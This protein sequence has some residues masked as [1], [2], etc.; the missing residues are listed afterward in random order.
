L[1]NKNSIGDALMKKIILF[2]ICLIAVVVMPVS[3]VNVPFNASTPGERNLG[4]SFEWTVNNVS[5]LADIHYNF[6]AYAFRDLGS[7]YTYH[8][9][10]WGQNFNQSA[11]PG[12]KFIAV[13]IRGIGEGTTWIGWGADRFNLWLYGNTTIKPEA[14]HLE[15]LP[16]R[17]GSENYRPA[18]IL[19]LENR[20]N[21]DGSWLSDEWYGWKD[22]HE[23]DRLEPGKS[24]AFDGF[25]IYQVPLQTN[26]ED[27]RLAGWFGFYG[28]AI[29]YLS[30][31]DI[32][33]ESP[34]KNRIIDI[35]LIEIQKQMGLRISDRISRDKV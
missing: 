1:D 27:L 16:I 29:W 11:D 9:K 17:Y 4:Q 32:L 26:P 8:S 18:V 14:T 34:E 33:Q 15:D 19:N 13:W 7:N 3:A 12:K 20:T 5:G 24:N 31:H 22:G 2:V 21:P 30:P 10:D 35:S 25:I 6:T 28:T 23:L